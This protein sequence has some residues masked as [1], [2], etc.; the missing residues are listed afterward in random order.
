MVGNAH[1]TLC[2]I[3]FSYSWFAFLVSCTA[4][5]KRI[6]VTGILIA[7]ISVVVVLPNSGCPE[8]S[9]NTE[10]TAAIALTQ[11][12]S[13]HIPLFIVIGVTLSNFPEFII[14]YLLFNRLYGT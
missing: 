9:S 13:K 3:F 2:K 11:H 10:P 5:Q 4:I 6:A 12:I 1:P 8:E 7:K 14:N